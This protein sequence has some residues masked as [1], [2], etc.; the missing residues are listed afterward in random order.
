[1]VRKL[2]LGLAGVAAIISCL[3]L[4]ATAAASPARYCGTIKYSYQGTTYR[5]NVYVTAG[6]LSCKGARDA[7]Y[8]YESGAATFPTTGWTCRL[9]DEAVWVVCQGARSTVRGIPWAGDPSLPKH[10]REC[11]ITTY[12]DQGSTYQDKVNVLGGSVSC[13][14]AQS[15]DRT[16]ET[17]PLGKVPEIPGWQ[18]DYDSQDSWVLCVSP[19]SILR[20]VAYTTPPPPSHG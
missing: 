18:C 8:G 17:E 20:G 19:T 13:G 16:A 5:D 14:E 7:D 12:H 1:M 10:A 11:G 3:C 4:A 15:I 2:S 6:K 9:E